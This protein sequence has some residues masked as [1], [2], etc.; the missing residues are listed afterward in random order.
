MNPDLTTL[1]IDVKQLLDGVNILVNKLDVLTKKTKT[2]AVEID[3]LSDE[4]N[5]VHS[6]FS[7]I[8]KRKTLIEQKLNTYINDTYLTNLSNS[9]INSIINTKSEIVIEDINK[10]K[11][12]TLAGITHE[13]TISGYDTNFSDFIKTVCAKFNIDCSD[14]IELYRLII[15]GVMYS[16]I[17]TKKLTKTFIDLAKSQYKIHIIKFN[18]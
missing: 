7:A 8:S 18:K 2:M 17:N 5:S 6:S 10:I 15:A 14:D 11:I 9:Q 1:S 3:I 4:I 16:S 13:F 12:S